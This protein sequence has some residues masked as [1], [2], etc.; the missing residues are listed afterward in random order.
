MDKK[1]KL[2]HLHNLVSFVSRKRVFVED[3]LHLLDAFYMFRK[4]QKDCAEV[5][6][7]EDSFINAIDDK[8]DF[9]EEEIDFLLKRFFSYTHILNEYIYAFKADHW[10]TQWEN[11]DYIDDGLDTKLVGNEEPIEEED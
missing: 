1:E 9:P 11:L 5:W 8:Y 3:N 10:E 4:A 7:E 6:I 2:K